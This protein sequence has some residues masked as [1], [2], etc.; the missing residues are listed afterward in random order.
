MQVCNCLFDTG[1]WYGQFSVEVVEARADAAAI[2]A[3]VAGVSFEIGDM[4]AAGTPAN[5]RSHQIASA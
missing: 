3:A 4:H 5:N 1:L 2:R